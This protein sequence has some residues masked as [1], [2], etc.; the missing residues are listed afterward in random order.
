MTNTTTKEKKLN[1]TLVSLF[2]AAMEYSAEEISLID[3]VNE[4]KETL[5][6][7]PKDELLNDLQTICTDYIKDEE[8]LSFIKS[9]MQEI[10]NMQEPK[11]IFDTKLGQ[12]MLECIPGDNDKEFLKSCPGSDQTLKDTIYQILTSSGFDNKWVQIILSN[13]DY[14]DDDNIIN[15]I[16]SPKQVIDTVV[17]P[18][19]TNHSSIVPIVVKDD[20]NATVTVDLQDMFSQENQYDLTLNTMFD[21]SSLNKISEKHIKKEVKSRIIKCINNSEFASE[22]LNHLG[23]DITTNVQFKLSSFEDKDNFTIVSTTPRLFD[24]QQKY[25]YFKFSANGGMFEVR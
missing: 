24:G 13:S 10:S 3:Y 15:I 12:Y 25:V 17:T 11:S 16:S 8:T 4:N 20:S 2:M 18:V 21:F 6:M 14:W 1:E 9:F 5:K 7:V 23:D 19:E 22:L